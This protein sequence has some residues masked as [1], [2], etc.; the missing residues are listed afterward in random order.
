M[1]YAE[2]DEQQMIRELVRDFA[3]SVLAPTVEHRDQNQIPPSEEWQEFLD[4][5]LQGVTIPEHTADRRWMIFQNP[6]LSRNLHEST[7]PS[8]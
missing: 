3:E 5:G 8:Q 7:H 4:Y 6:S 1:D 2:T